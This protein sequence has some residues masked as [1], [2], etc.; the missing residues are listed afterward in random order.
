MGI[1][2][3]TLANNITTS[4]VLASSGINNVSLNNVTSIP[5]SIETGAI[6]LLNTADFDGETSASWTSQFD[7]STYKEYWWVF[8]NVRPSVDDGDFTFNFSTDGGSSYNVSKAQTSQYQTNNEADDTNA[9][10][11][12]TNSDSAQD[13]NDIILMDNVGNEAD[14]GFSG[15]FKLMNPAASV[16]KQ[17]FVDLTKYGGGDNSVYW[18]YSGVAYTTSEINGFIVSGFGNNISNGTIKMYGI[19]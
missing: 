13:T 19:K 16:N 12:N 14:Q 3:R 11:Y 7:S 8:N 17:F 6:V 9:L 10:S 15:I 5:A 4:G 1:I 18:F 2:R